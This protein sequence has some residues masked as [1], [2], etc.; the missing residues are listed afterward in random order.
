[1]GPQTTGIFDGSSITTNSDF[2][3]ETQCHNLGHAFGH[4]AQWSLDGPRCECLY[5][6]LNSAKERRAADPQALETALQRF[7][8]YEDEASGHA[9]WLLQE[10]GNAAALGS[11]TLFARADIDAIVSYHR[12]GVAP[13]W[14]EFFAAWQAKAA[15]G[16]IEVREFVPL[17]I[18][19][20]I[21]LPIAPQ[22]VV[23]GVRDFAV[24]ESVETIDSIR[25]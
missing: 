5:A 16:E 25:R 6:A 15:R 21:P 9:A 19:P 2:D 18:P 7:R 11:F 8:E 24:N 1:M 13:I 10:T 4:I 20:F 3:L 17:P 14:N 23:R 22:E 12:D